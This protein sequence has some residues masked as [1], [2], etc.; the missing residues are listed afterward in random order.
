MGHSGT[1]P[2]RGAIGR[3]ARGAK[4]Q[5][6]REKVNFLDSSKDSLCKSC[7]EI[8]HLMIFVKWK[9]E[10]AVRAYRPETANSLRRRGVHGIF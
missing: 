8:V 6:F 10:E 9:L 5:N 1:I 3:G 4:G 2:S 7:K